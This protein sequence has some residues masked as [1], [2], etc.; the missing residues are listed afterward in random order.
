MKD[1][2]LSTANLR[3]LAIILTCDRCQHAA[4]YH[5]VDAENEA[6]SECDCPRFERIPEED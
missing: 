2:L 5:D 4:S 6:C 3:K 1:P